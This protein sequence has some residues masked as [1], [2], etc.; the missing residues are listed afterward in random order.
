MHLGH[1]RPA[2][3]SV[4]NEGTA[5][6]LYDGECNLCSSVVAFVLPRDRRGRFR[7]SALQSDAGRRLLTA[8][9]CLDPGFSTVM[10][11]E[12]NRCRTRSDAVLR[13][14]RLLPAPWPLLAGLRLVPRPVRDAAY[15]LI[16]RQRGRWFGRRSTC[17]LSAAGWEDRF[18]A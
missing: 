2:R 14:L 7:F 8:V 16:A 3:R 18:L 4:I 17:L 13:I 11:V 9:N 5:V 10:L 15:G 1:P 6:I 12:D